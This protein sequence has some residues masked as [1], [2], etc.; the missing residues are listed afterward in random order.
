[1]L[2][3][4]LNDLFFIGA[5]LKEIDDDYK[6]FY[7][8]KKQ[9]FEIHC[10]GQIGGSYCLTVPYACLDART[11]EFVRKTRVENREKLIDEIDRENLK[12]QEKNQ[13]TILNE[14]KDKLFEQIK[15]SKL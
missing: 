9:K 10:M 8:T 15:Y 1:M 11:I 14:A 5:R 6:I 4:I 13:K 2:V 3:E 7:N 12:N